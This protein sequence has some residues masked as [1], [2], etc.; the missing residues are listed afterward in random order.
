MDPIETADLRDWLKSHIGQATVLDPAE[1]LEACAKAI[2]VMS[3]LSKLIRET[4]LYNSKVSPAP[5]Q[6][7]NLSD[8]TLHE[9]LSAYQPSEAEFEQLRIR[10]RETL[11]KIAAREIELS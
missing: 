4:E 5:D 6:R 8:M 2:S 1:G 9:R 3:A 11:I 10:F 7:V